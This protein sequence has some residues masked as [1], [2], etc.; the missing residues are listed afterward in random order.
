M[1]FPSCQANWRNTSDSRPRQQGRRGHRSYSG[2]SIV[3]VSPL[4]RSESPDPLVAPVIETRSVPFLN[5][6]RRKGRHVR[7]SVTIAASVKG[8]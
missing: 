6:T 7:T 4:Y 5:Y 2:I 1:L 8:R 3:I